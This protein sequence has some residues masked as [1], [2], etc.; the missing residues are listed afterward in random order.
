M[1]KPKVQLVILCEDR[2]QERLVRRLWEHHPHAGR[3]IR[4]EIAPAGRGSGAQWVASHYAA[5]AR[6]Y[7]SQANHLNNGLVVV[8]D[9]DNLGVDGR[10]QQ[11][12]EALR[13]DQQPERTKEERIA[14]LVPTWSIET[15]L[16]WL[17]GFSIDEQTPYKGTPVYR[18]GCDSGSVTPLRASQEWEREPRAG[19]PAGLTEGRKELARITPRRPA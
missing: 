10:Q 6:A 15:W 4:V 5:Q 16:L 8:I 7:R 1:G 2:E 3:I 13:A 14:I 19:E 9:G 18:S 11:L 17:C 12:Q